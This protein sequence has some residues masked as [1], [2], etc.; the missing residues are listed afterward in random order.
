[1]NG[2]IRDLHGR[3]EGKPMK[4]LCVD[5][6]GSSM[7]Y[8][9]M[10]EKAEILE[11]GK[12]SLKEVSSVSD[13]VSVIRRQYEEYGKPEGGI[14]ISYCGELDASTGLLY[15]GG[16]YP[17]MASCNLKDILEKECQTKASVENDGNCAAIAELA[18]GSLK[19]C[20]NAFVLL[21][22]KN[23]KLDWTVIICYK[24]LCNS[25]AVIWRCVVYQDA[26]DF[27]VVR[28]AHY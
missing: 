2:T 3:K 15:N 10:S 13:M 27:A 20:R 28:L 9:L 4:Y 1:M 19:D 18:S 26:F 23:F 24:A 8:C 6:G 5:I 16:S 17:F 25:Y 21:V 22:V 12:T 14:A 7:K 11:K